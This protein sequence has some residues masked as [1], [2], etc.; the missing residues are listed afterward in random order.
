[1]ETASL[2]DFFTFWGWLALGMGLLVFELLAPG[3]FF[4][5]LAIAAGATGLVVLVLPDLSWQGQ[6]ML[7]GL[8]SIVSV[9]AG[10]RLRGRA[11]PT[12]HPT[13]NRR[14]EQYVGRHFTLEGPIVNGQGKLKVD[15]TTW[16]VTGPDLPGGTTV[17]VVGVD[18]T[19]LR[20]DR[21]PEG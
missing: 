14:G 4:L 6:L 13:L 1:M 17:V 2:F 15:D 10:Y 5:W 19:Q 7:F 20:V 18:G 21:I 12:D 3:V 11:G 9:V 8:L 16:K